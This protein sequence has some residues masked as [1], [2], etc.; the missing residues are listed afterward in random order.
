MIIERWDCVEITRGMF[1]GCISKVEQVMGS[2]LFG[3]WVRERYIYFGEEYLK[4]MYGK[5]K[6]NGKLL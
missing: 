4:K 1:K 6:Q 5:T 3:M 2:G